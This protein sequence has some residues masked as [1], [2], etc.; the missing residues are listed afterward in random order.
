MLAFLR[1]VVSPGTAVFLVAA[2]RF[3]DRE[4]FA[5]M[6]VARRLKSIESRANKTA[7]SNRS[8]GDPDVDFRHL[9]RSCAPLQRQRFLHCQV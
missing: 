2:R 4:L 3:L 6:M 7:L 1:T 5:E 8:G 9:L